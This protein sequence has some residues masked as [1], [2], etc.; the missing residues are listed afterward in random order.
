MEERDQG[1]RGDRRDSTTSEETEPGGKL[2]KPAAKNRGNGFFG[3]VSQQDR[4]D[5]DSELGGR[6]LPIEILQGGLDHL[7]LLVAGLH[8]GI[9]AGATGRDQGKLGR[10]KERICHHQ[11]DQGEDP[12]PHRRTLIGFHGG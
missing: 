8:H 5:R 7:G 11:H 1:N 6:E 9:D 3:D 10:H 2:G 12:K 4:S